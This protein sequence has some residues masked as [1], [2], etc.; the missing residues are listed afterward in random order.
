MGSVTPPRV[1]NIN[2]PRSKLAGNVATIPSTVG[3][4]HTLVAAGGAGL[5]IITD[6]SQMVLLG[7]PLLP[8]T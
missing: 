7:I 3:P 6:V 1:G 8:N 5:T 4:S 2:I